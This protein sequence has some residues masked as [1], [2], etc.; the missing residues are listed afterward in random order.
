[1]GRREEVRGGWHII[2]VPVNQV[3]LPIPDD[4]ET[5]LTCK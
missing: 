2:A 4:A 3:G 1:V 5:G